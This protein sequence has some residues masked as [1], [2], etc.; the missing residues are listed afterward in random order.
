MTTER[1]MLGAIILMAAAVF[2]GPSLSQ[3][4][5]TGS[6]LS[7]EQVHR[8]HLE[9]AAERREKS[10]QMREQAMAEAMKQSRQQAREQSLREALKVRD[11]QWPLIRSK[12]MKVYDLQ[13]EANVAVRMKDAREV[14]ATETLRA[15]KAGSST[16]VTTT[17]RSYEDWRYTKSWEQ[18]TE[19]TKGQK[20]CDELVALLEAGDA[21]DEQKLEKMNA[22]RQARQQA[23]KELAAAQQQLREALSLRQQA[24]L[25]MT[26]LLN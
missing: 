13:E 17:T 1:M 9:W 10:G 5:R 16:P 3:T 23:T 18:E 11:A 2:S 26:G 24:T 4:Q 20:A 25:V 22:L 15:G 7:S 21:T 8:R 14:I 6:R 19:L 12:L